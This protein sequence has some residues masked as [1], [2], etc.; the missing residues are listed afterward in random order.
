MINMTTIKGL[1]NS[2]VPTI[3]ENKLVNEALELL[4]E[5]NSSAI[6]IVNEYLQPLGI[7]TQRDITKYAGK[8][9]EIIF[10]PVSA[11][12]STPLSTIGEEDDFRDAYMQ[13]TEN[14]FRHLVVVKDDLSLAGLL[15]EGDFLRH[16]A[17]EQLLAVKEVHLVM[18]KNVTTV[19][20]TQSVAETINIM[21]MQKISSIVVVSD[22]K[23]LGVFT[24]RDSIRLAR[25]G[26]KNLSSVISKHMSSPVKTITENH[27]VMDA[28]HI[29]KN[30]NIRH[31]VVV[32]NEGELSGII[33]QHDLVKGI[34]GIY[35]EMLR[36]TIRKQADILYETFNR[37]EEH[38]VLNNILN[39][40]SD[41]LIIAC[42]THNVIEFT[43]ASLFQ[44]LYAV[45]YEGEVLDE[46]LACFDK[47]IS[48]SILSGEVTTIQNKSTTVLDSQA[49]EH[50]FKTSYVPIYSDEKILQGFLFT[51]ENIT[52]EILT[53]SELK[54]T[55]DLLEEQNVLLKK[56]EEQLLQA[57]EIAKIGSWSLDVNT[58]Q[59]EWSDQIRNIL[60]IGL[61]VEVGPKF[62]SNLVDPKERPKLES[63]LMGAV[64]YGKPHHME[65]KIT[66][67]TDNQVRWVECQGVRLYDEEGIPTKVVGTFQ[68]ITEK[69][70][71][72]LQITETGTLFKAIF[73][74]A[75]VGVAQIDSNTGRFIKVNQTYADI[76]GLS[77]EEML[78]IDFMKV[79]H[80]DELEED[81][82]NM[83][84]MKNK[85]IDTFSMRKRYYKS[86]GGTVWI[87]LHVSPL[88][89]KN[90]KLQSHIA[91][92]EDVTKEH[93]A[94][95]SERKL[96]N[97][98][99]SSSNEF[100]V[101]DKDTLLFSYANTGALNNLQYNLEELQKL[102]VYDL[103]LQYT[104]DVFKKTIEPLIKKKVSQ[105]I[106]ET[107]HMRKDGTTYPVE[108]NLQLLNTSEEKEDFLAVVIDITNRHKI[109]AK[110]QEQEE[111]MIVQSRQ[112]A[113][114]EMINM[115]AHQWR[116]PLSVLSMTANNI[117]LD[118]QTNKLNEIRT[119]EDLLYINEQ[120][121]YMSTTIEDFRNFF[122]HSKA[123]EK[124]TVS[125]IIQD[126]LSI[127]GPALDSNGIDL[128]LECEPSISI[129]TY[130]SE[131]KQVMINIL[132][133]AKDA[134]IDT[135]KDKK[136]SIKVEAE[137]EKVTF[138]FT[139]NGPQIAPKT[140]MT[141]FEPYFT[142]KELS[143][144]SGL[145][146]YMSKAIVEKHMQGKI[147]AK[148]VN[149]GV[150][151]C[152]CVPK[153]LESVY[154][155]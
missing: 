49:K 150:E 87:N 119:E 130:K 31:L 121:Q 82:T 24:E 94:L 25:L 73:D 79:S 126:V 146:L 48:D 92:V 6:V 59:A 154:S 47:T 104:A 112:A 19:E 90:G 32:N 53:N 85:E 134:L 122:K 107:A 117:L 129:T 55:K 21:T 2:D 15:D 132:S 83:Q 63:S 54:E 81:L 135:F 28:E 147:S 120:I 33:S 3:L 125:N 72:E 30:E 67:P 86:D 65:Y 7:L 61:D 116:Q 26:D 22:K 13:M 124:D 114:G 74:Q 39:S 155:E 148:N 36:D 76:L 18:S 43:N 84:A 141:I 71:L 4:D 78:K 1:Y 10:S 153:V 14:A 20:E 96:L 88:H 142:T 133:N 68:D 103:K 151:F 105:L 127:I 95:E 52:S 57:Q 139:N 40:F 111:M 17:P 27:S 101:F 34:S 62:L 64:K 138:F 45:P 41:R 113:M 110:L 102:R 91:I 75:A 37:L 58:L 16:L 69:K 89:W 98:I 8:W 12:M 66:R 144:G 140:L 23:P 70:E 44:S 108:V 11:V 35:V 9:D 145:G 56:R 29:L 50:F 46:R 149:N 128:K 51:A 77:I 136:I 60:D 137:K 5:T 109:E 115:I 93:E 38:S 131:L 143:G 80:P 42:D 100:Y 118:I 152:I 99:D 97:L 123:L 106:F